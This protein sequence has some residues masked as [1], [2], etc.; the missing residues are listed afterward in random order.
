MLDAEAPRDARAAIVADDGKAIVAERVHH[1][2]VVLR[3]GALRVVRVIV[4]VRRFAAVAVAAQVRQDD[5]EALRQARRDLV[6]LDVG[7]RIA[8]DHQERRTG[9]ADECMNRRARRLD[10]TRLEAREQCRV[11]GACAAAPSR[12]AAT[13]ADAPSVVVRNSRRS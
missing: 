9:P 4:A 1:V 10:V 13:I 8:V 6:P 5:R 7:L 12:E 3:H 2:D 11:P